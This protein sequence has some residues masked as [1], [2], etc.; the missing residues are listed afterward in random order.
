[1]IRPQ[2][3]AISS[4]VASMTHSSQ[5]AE[6]AAPVSIFAQAHEK[7]RLRLHFWR[8]ERALRRQ[9]L[10]QLSPELQAARSQHLGTLHAYGKQGRFPRNFDHP[11]EQIPCFIDREGHVCAVA[12][13][14]I[15]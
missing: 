11:G 4:E 14:L 15:E 7:W 3:L 5:T 1:M 6:T 9:A 10:P 2:I 12:H 8:V 13:L